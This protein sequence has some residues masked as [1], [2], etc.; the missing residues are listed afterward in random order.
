VR[1]FVFFD[2]RPRRRFADYLRARDVPVEELQD[3]DAYGV[4]IPE[5]TDDGLMDEI[6]A[7][8]EKMMAF[9][10]DLFEADPEAGEGQ[11]AGVVVN[12]ESG[13]TVCARVDPGLP[14]RIMGVLTPQ[15]PGEVVNAIVDAV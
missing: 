15:E 5:D 9:D 12:L 3:D 10:Q 8:C 7:C 11:A 14:G 6:E 1:E 13:D 4:A 2:L